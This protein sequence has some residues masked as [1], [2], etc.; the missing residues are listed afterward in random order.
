MLSPRLYKDKTI[1]DAA[2]QVIQFLAELL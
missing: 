1:F 2:D